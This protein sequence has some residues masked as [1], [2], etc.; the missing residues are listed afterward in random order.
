[1][2]LW[3]VHPSYLDARG[4]VA[5]WREGLLARRVLEGRTRGYR[6]HPQLARFRSQ[7]DPIVAID[8]YLWGVFD[9]SCRR[10]YCFDSSKLGP[11]PSRI[12]IRETR[13]QLAHEWSHL[14]AKLRLRAPSLWQRIR[15]M[16][17]L[18]AHPVF[19]IVP[20]AVQPWERGVQASTSVERRKSA[21]TSRPAKNAAR[22][23]TPS[24]RS[25]RP[26]LRTTALTRPRA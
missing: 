2:R 6:H 11:R 24:M 10:G 5:L 26:K 23:K 25:M 16:N 1:M 13:G 21:A 15:A 12:T 22:N 3:T 7:P 17:R 14:R 4:L 8:A 18:R 9:E 20:G 19:A